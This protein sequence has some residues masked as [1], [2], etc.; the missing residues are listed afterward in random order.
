MADQTLWSRGGLM[1]AGGV[2]LGSLLLT[3]CALPGTTAPVGNIGTVHVAGVPAVAAP[4]KIVVSPSNS[5]QGVGLDAPVLVSVSTGHLDTVSL[6]EAG[7][8]TVLAGVM[9]PD[10]RSW[11]MTH[12]LDQGAHYT[13]VATATSTAGSTS[14]ST[15]TFV[16]LTAK[17][18]LLTGMTPLDGAV[19]G[20]GETIDLRF[21][22]AIPAGVRAAL[23]ERIQVTSTPAVTGG[24]HWLTAN[25]VHFRPAT[26]WPAGTKVTVTANLTGFDVGSG[27]WGLGDWT[28]SFSVGAKHL[29]II[30]NA[31]HTMQVF[32][33]NKM[34][35]SYPVSL[36]KGGFATIQGTLIVL[37]KTPVVVMKSCPTFHTPAACIPGGSQYYND[38]VYEDTAISTSGYFIHAA[39][40]S[41][42]SQGR[43][44]VSHGCVNLS[45]SR[46]T[47]FYN[48]SI[49]GDVVQV[50][51]TGYNAS[52]S[53]GE[54]D[55]QLSFAAF[56]NTLGL[57]PVWTGP[58][59]SSSLPGRVS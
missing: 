16:T 33:N 45:N 15:T 51:N 9:S 58:V 20:V 32:N 1:L 57:G 12:A 4:P 23:L 53:D 39:P 59:N 56:S 46:A 36:G 11:Q 22:T 31:T 34:I 21:N 2:A 3:S 10:G 43:A 41:V 48:F 8:S 44:D 25:V 6:S 42:G 35:A 29:S 55:W 19:V 26:F 38:P 7:S 5:A 13:V 37:Y 40:W 52:Y 30:N 54:G 49:P 50:E 24:W 18:R 17:S 28:S 27:I 47:T 14:T